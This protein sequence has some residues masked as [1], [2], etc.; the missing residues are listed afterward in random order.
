M[1]N[2]TSPGEIYNTLDM[3]SQTEDF[4]SVTVFAVYSVLTVL[5]RLD[6]RIG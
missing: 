2:I 4:L 6:V 5:Y 1:L 3:I